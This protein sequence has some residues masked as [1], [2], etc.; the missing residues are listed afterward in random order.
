VT[1]SPVIGEVDFR[2]LILVFPPESG[3]KPL[4]VMPVSPYGDATEKGDTAE[5]LIIRIRQVVLYRILT[6]VVQSSTRPGLIR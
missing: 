2:D 5:D 6:G 3:L 4:Y 1:V